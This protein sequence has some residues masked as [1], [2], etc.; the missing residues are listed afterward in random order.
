MT[1]A[2]IEALIPIFGIFFVFGM[3][4]ALVFMWKWFKLKEKELAVDAELRRTSG[5]ALEQRVQRLESIILA[6]DADLRTRLGAAD[7]L[8]RELVQPPAVQQDE[9]PEPVPEPTRLR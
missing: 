1:P 7:L 8:P 3:P 9:L 6:L 5:Q 4:V 2:L